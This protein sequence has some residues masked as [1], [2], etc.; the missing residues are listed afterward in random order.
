MSHII[1]WVIPKQI[2]LFV[3]SFIYRDVQNN[4]NNWYSSVIGGRLFSAFCHKNCCH[5]TIHLCLKSLILMFYHSVSVLSISAQIK[6]DILNLSVIAFGLGVYLQV[7]CR[8]ISSCIMIEKL[9]G[10]RLWLI[11]NPNLWMS[12]HIKHWI[13]LHTLT[14][15]LCMGRWICQRSA[16]WMTLRMIEWGLVKWT[17]NLVEGTVVCLRF[18]MRKP[19]LQS[20]NEL[21]QPGL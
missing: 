19:S 13:G 10:S 4:E 20:T 12:F 18:W 5:H 15:L 8:Y 3:C 16:E 7:F 21:G 2:F 9:L 1:S 17:L 6:I 11:S 14:V